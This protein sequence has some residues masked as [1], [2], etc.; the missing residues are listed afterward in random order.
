MATWVI[1]LEAP[2]LDAPSVSKVFEYEATARAC[3]LELC[4]LG[5]RSS[6]A[7]SAV[8]LVECDGAGGELVLGWFERGVLGVAS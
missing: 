1:V 3:F 5:M 4:A 6:G 7:V 8:R 2:D